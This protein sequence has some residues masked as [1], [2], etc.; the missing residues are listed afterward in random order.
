[1]PLFLNVYLDGITTFNVLRVIGESYLSLRVLQQ[2]QDRNGVSSSSILFGGWRLA[3]RLEYYRHLLVRRVNWNGAT[4]KKKKIHPEECMKNKQNSY[5][6]KRDCL[7]YL[8]KM[9]MLSEFEFPCNN[10]LGS[11]LSFDDFFHVCISASS[12]TQANSSSPQK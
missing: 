4:K 3:N 8:N 10:S 1:M 9:L 6:F 7:W 11:N 12:I 2:Q 5:S